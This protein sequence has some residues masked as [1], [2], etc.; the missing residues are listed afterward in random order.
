MPHVTRRSVLSGAGALGIGAALAACGST[1]SISSDPDE[2]VLWYWNRSASPA[3]L[4]Q[5]SRRIPDTSSHLRA[6]IIGTS[7]D[8]K[9]RTSLAGGSYIPDITFVN[10]NN[11][12]YFRNENQFLDMNDLG[13]RDAA[14]DYF[15]WKWKLGTT[16]SDRFCFF[17]LDIGPTGFYYR[18]DV[19]EKAGLPSSVEDV[20]A[21][22]TTWEDWIAL[23]AELRRATGAALVNTAQGIFDQFLNASP[24]RYFDDHDRPLYATDGS[25]V[26]Q[27]W[28]TA[29]AAITADITAGIPDARGP[30]QNAALSK[31]STAGHI[32]AAWWAQILQ[33]SA[34]DTAGA[35]RVADQPVRAGNSGGSFAA[36]PHTCKD[37]SAA[38]DFIR[39]LNLPAH[40]AATYNEVQL[41]PSTP[42]AYASGTMRYQGDFFGDQD[43]LAFFHHA[44]ETVPTSFISTWESAVSGYF[45]LE[46]TNVETSGKDPEVAWSDALAASE[47]I[48]RKR[49]VLS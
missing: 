33:E 16:P 39:W 17:P 40:Q 35:W 22:T 37:P 12:L 3:L 9:L 19:F 27:A 24:E 36:I 15:E 8:T 18:Q 45:T 30:D 6:D 13:A 43:P 4:E 34:P 10:S 32:Q 26:R 49:G 46:I 7:F 47:K 1:T 14:S 25:V 42:A 20:S 28:D 31:G 29:V 5:A 2:L 41:F 38:Y 11:A 21:A 23:G 48:L 44:A